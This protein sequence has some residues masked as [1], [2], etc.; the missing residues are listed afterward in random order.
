M[1]LENEIINRDSDLA[2]TQALADQLSTSLSEAQNENRALQA[3]LANSRSASAA[4]ES[5]GAKTPGSAMRSKTS[6]QR[7]IM[8]GS[9]EAA[10]A[11]QVAQ[12]KEDLYGD[13]TGLILLGVER[14]DES[15]IYDCIQTG[16]NGSR[17]SLHIRGRMRSM[18]TPDCSAPLQARDS[19]RDRRRLRKHGVP[20]HAPLGR[21]PRPRYDGVA[22]RIP[23][24][25]DHVLTD[26]R[27]HVL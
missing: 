14:T 23:H 19:Q 3:K 15:D 12:L 18:L 4:V 10:Y 20:I 21:Q 6:A 11:A 1:S 22:A 13:L 7:T 26:E 9:A 8:V 25:R 5:L 16:R 27:G 2:K 17:C 24:G